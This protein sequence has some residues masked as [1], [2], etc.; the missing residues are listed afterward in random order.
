[1]GRSI[2]NPWRKR[3]FMRLKIAWIIYEICLEIKKLKLLYRF[4]ISENALNEI[5]Q[6][7]SIVKQFYNSIRFLTYKF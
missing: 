3:D 4:I 6:I 5:K 7:K 2:K 1:M